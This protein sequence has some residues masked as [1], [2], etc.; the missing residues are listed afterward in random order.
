MTPLNLTRGAV[1]TLVLNLSLLLPLA[2]NPKV[3]QYTI[4]LTN[5]Y[6]VVLGIPWFIL[7]KSRRG[8][9]LPKGSHWWSVSMVTCSGMQILMNIRSD[10]SR[11]TMRLRRLDDSR[12]WSTCLSPD[13]QVHLRIPRCI[14]PSRRRS[15]YERDIGGDRSEPEDSVLVPPIDIPHIGQRNLLS[16]LLLRLLISPEI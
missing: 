3:D 8:P 1:F 6:W 15:Q 11:S 7:Q 10:G 4:G 9:A 2:S 12:E 5:A 16:L 13:P 14:L